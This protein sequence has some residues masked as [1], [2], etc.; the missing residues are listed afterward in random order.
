M[1]PGFPVGVG[2]NIRF[3]QNFQ[4]KLHEIEIILG[5]KGVGAPLGPPMK[6]FSNMMAASSSYQ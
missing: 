1:D 6:E 5:R 4:K 3:C 2:A